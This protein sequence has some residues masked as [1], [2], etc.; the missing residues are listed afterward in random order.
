M[1]TIIK[2]FLLAVALI[3]YSG[4]L[5]AQENNKQRLT[6]EQLAEVQAKHIAKILELDD[7]KSKQF[8]ETY[9]QC[10]KEIWNIGPR[11]RK[12]QAVETTDAEVEQAMKERFEHSQKLLNIRQKYY[13]E[14]SK[15][16]TQKQIQRVY[17]QEKRIMERL[18]KKRSNGPKYNKQ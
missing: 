9:C 2:V 1:K 4:G 11:T 7:V 18:S 6:R 13:A 16:L 5:S 8:I 15:F 12:S 10:Q 3:A 17:E 14:Y